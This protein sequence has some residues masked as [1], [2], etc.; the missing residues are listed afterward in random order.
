MDDR[1]HFCEIRL[2]KSQGICLL[3][4]IEMNLG[5]IKR[6]KGL[7]CFNMLVTLII[8]ILI[9]PRIAAQI[10]YI[11]GVL[12][13]GI[14]TLIVFISEYL[15][16]L[17]KYKDNSVTIE[18]YKKYCRNQGIVLLVTVCLVFLVNKIIRW[19]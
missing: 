9:Q 3:E 17:K 6:N 19:A 16:V 18:Q 13:T 5:K 8:C 10:S 7:I 2:K 14:L 1:Q 12:A 4:V 11:Q 15:W